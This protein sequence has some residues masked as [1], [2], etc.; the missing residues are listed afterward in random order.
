MRV[1]L[2]V[3]ILLNLVLGVGL[4]VAAR[5]N[6]TGAIGFSDC[7]RGDGPEG[8]CCY[9]C[10]WIAPVCESDSDCQDS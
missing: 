7:C 3:L 9:R 4:L 1:T 10:C 2:I 6:A 8:Y 5:N